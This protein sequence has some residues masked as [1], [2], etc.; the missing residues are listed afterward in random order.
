M[1]ENKLSFEQ[2]MARLDEIVR[3]LEKGDA[4]LGESLGLFREGTMLIESCNAMLNEA[5]Q[6]V[7]KLRKG[8]DGE[9]VELPFEE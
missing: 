5:E 1:N 9:P 7:V 6:I 2:S 4:P 3:M 8:A